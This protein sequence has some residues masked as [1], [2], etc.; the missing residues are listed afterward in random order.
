VV[1]R[2]QDVYLNGWNGCPGSEKGGEMQL[3]RTRFRSVFLCLILCLAVVLIGM[4]K[5]LAQ[6]MTQGK[7]EESPNGPTP[8]LVVD[9]MVYDYGEVMRG[10]MINHTFVIRNKGKA[11][12]II[13][14]AQPD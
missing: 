11:E 14:K 4:G 6:D 10:E 12:L 7:E 2:S 5:I 8:K 1:I 9:S 13:K 3:K